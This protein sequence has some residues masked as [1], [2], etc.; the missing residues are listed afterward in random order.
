MAEKDCELLE[1]QSPGSHFTSACPTAIYI[2]LM[3]HEMR[4]NHMS[5]SAARL[6]GLGLISAMDAVGII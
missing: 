2:Y 1:E 3:I 5:V 6:Y 4:L